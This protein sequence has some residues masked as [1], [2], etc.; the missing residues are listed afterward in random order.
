MQ[1]IPVIQRSKLMPIF[2]TLIEN[3]ICY[4]YGTPFAINND[5][6]HSKK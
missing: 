3:T 4:K 2:I 5:I 1:G 6:S